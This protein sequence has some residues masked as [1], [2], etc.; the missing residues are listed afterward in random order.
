MIDHQEFPNFLSLLSW[1]SWWSP[2]PVSWIQGRIESIPCTLHSLRSKRKRTRSCLNE[3]RVAVAIFRIRCSYAEEFH[4]RS[5]LFLFSLYLILV[6][7]ISITWVRCLPMKRL[8]STVSPFPCPPAEGIHKP[9]PTPLWNSSHRGSQGS[10]TFSR[11][12]EHAGWESYSLREWSL[13]WTRTNPCIAYTCTE[14]L[15]LK[16]API[17]SEPD[18]CWEK[19]EVGKGAKRR[20]SNLRPPWWTDAIFCLSIVQEIFSTEECIPTS[21]TWR[22]KFC[23]SINFKYNSAQERFQ[24]LAKSCR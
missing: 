1:Y 24:G 3:W 17:R 8:E 18:V 4:E 9:E 7:S 20:C 15:Q 12:R 21:C 11:T 14:R 16:S 13:G 23:R 2:R 5:Q 19:K 10:Q 6:A 22:L